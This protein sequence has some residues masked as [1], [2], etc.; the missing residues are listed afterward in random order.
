MSPVERPPSLVWAKHGTD[1]SG[2]S[3][4]CP[5][6]HEEEARQEEHKPPKGTTEVGGAGLTDG[7][8]GGGEGEAR[9]G[10]KE[11]RVTVLEGGEMQRVLLRFLLLFR[12]SIIVTS[13]T[14]PVAA[15]APTIAAP[16]PPRHD[17]V[18]VQSPS[19]PQ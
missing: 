5:C 10:G 13:A 8:D 12:Y 3:D 16:P 11:G 1:G 14:D 15:A 19:H 4:Q 7:R 9:E 6:P 18:Q 2:L 17:R